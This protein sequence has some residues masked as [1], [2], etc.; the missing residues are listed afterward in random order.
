[1]ATLRRTV[2]ASSS[3]VAAAGNSSSKEGGHDGTRVSNDSSSRT[4]ANILPYIVLGGL[5]GLFLTHY[6][7]SDTSNTNTIPNPNR[8]R[9]LDLMGKGGGA[10]KSSTLGS[11]GI[12]LKDPPESSATTS[13]S[14]S[15][16]PLPPLP[17]YEPKGKEQLEQEAAEK[18]KKRKITAIALTDQDLF[19]V[20]VHR[21]CKVF[22]GK[23]HN[24]G[25]KG[26][27][28][29]IKYR[30]RTQKD[31]YEKGCK[32]WGLTG[33]WSQRDRK[34]YYSFMFADE[35]EILNVVLH[36][37][38]PVVDVIIIL[39]C[40]TTWQGEK[41]PLFF[42]KLNQSMETFKPYADKI[43]YIPYD[44][45]DPRTA[46]FLSRCMSEEL[47]GP[48]WPPGIMQCRWIRQWG[49]RDYLV[50]GAKDIRPHDVFIV[51]DLDELLAREYLRA[52]H[53]CDVYP[54]GVEGG[55]NK[56]GRMGVF[57]FGHKYYFDCTVDRPHGH[58]HPNLV[59]GRCLNVIGAEELKRWWGEPKKYFPKP[60]GLLD[61]KMS[62]PGGWHMHSFLSTA[63]VLWKWFSRSG[64]SA[65]EHRGKWDNRWDQE[66]LVTIRK[67]REKCDEQKTF[68]SFDS[69][70]CEP[71]PHLIRE[72]PAD[73][74]HFIRYVPDE[75]I[76]DLYGLQPWYHERLLQKRDDSAGK[77]DGKW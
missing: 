61:S 2:H 11:D 44:F 66:D 77:F 4:L 20:P 64:R 70:A 46:D 12:I 75:K 26:G 22:E 49:A 36:E 6:V 34:I 54:E 45:E 40:T 43:R 17:P 53:H 3:N 74:A 10:S 62:G 56:C 15:P 28:G 41:K 19:T 63:R 9:G 58:Y 39:E 1:M 51:A 29:T 21:E 14:I 13:T 35:A 65:R 32:Q 33:E 67:Q 18:E 76:P 69:E 50:H 47:A 5:F 55:E 68:L 8:N 37:I 30:D 23:F 31:W 60:E 27:H 59:L 57:T 52:L 72:H 16:P 73:W 42:P 7:I 24:T 48:N 38:Y 71:L 25:K